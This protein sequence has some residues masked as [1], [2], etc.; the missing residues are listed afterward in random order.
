MTQ[1]HHDETPQDM[2]KR[3]FS[4]AELIIQS[5]GYRQAQSITADKKHKTEDL[6]YGKSHNDHLERN[7][8]TEEA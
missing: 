3:V 5:D 1:S 2:M 4:V 6:M 8:G 7:H